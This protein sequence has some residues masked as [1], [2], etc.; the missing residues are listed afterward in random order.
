MFEFN[1]Y[2]LLRFR[3]FVHSCSRC[4]VVICWLQVLQ[5]G[6]SVLI[7]RYSCVI[8]DCPIR[9]LVVAVLFFLL[10]LLL[11]FFGRNGVLCCVF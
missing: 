6:G 2:L 4:C 3:Y 8:L 5:K 1:P 7:R 10:I 11:V 9:S